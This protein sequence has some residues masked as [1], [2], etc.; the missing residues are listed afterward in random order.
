MNGLIQQIADGTTSGLI[1]A[2]VAL[3]LVMIYKSTHQIN[4]AQGEMAVFSTYVALTLLAA[5]VPY[6]IAFLFA[7]IISFLGG[8]AIERLLIRP[9][10]SA[11]A[12]NVVIVFIGL[13]AITNSITGWIWGFNI[14]T[15]PS[16]FSAGN[17]YSGGYLSQHQIGMAAL[18]VLELLAVFVFFRFTSVGL[19]MRAAA[20]NPI[21]SRLSGVRVN[22]MLSIGWGMAAAIGAVAGILTAPMVFLDPNMMSGVLISSFAGALLGGLQ[23]PGGAVVGGILVGI[24]EALGGAYLVGP[25]LKL[26]LALVVIILVLLIKP[27]GLF[28][29]TFVSRV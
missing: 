16:P 8:I 9:L 20:E 17:W 22:Q 23:S 29:R 5:G 6:W 4:F 3:A 15:F 18:I 11:P 25:E 14:R 19:R 10:A 13:L 7:V 2:S 24:M 12:L 28:G 1:Y 21:S 27:S 26:T